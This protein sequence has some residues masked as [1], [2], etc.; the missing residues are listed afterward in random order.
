MRTYLAEGGLIDFSKEKLSS[1][2]INL[3]SLLNALANENR[4][5]NQTGYSV[6]QHSI[7]CGMAAKALYP[8][9]IRVQRHAAFHDIQ[10]AIIRDVPTPFK[11]MVGPQFDLAENKIQAKIYEA[12]GID[13]TLGLSEVRNA[14]QEIDAAM[15]FVEVH[16]FFKEDFQRQLENDKHKPKV[17]MA[18]TKAF[19]VM[20]ETD[21]YTDF[22]RWYRYA[23]DKAFHFFNDLLPLDYS[24]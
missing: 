22:I 7:A 8:E 2:E 18:C 24:Q 17:I 12:F 9:Y 14:V 5:S 20:M 19:N 16:A 21:D 1:D 15:L 4:F 6:L 10:E 3:K 11:R 23:N 13:D